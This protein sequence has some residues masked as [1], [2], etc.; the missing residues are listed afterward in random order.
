MNIAPTPRD[1]TGLRTRYFPKARI[2]H[3]FI[4]IVPWV[5]MLLLVAAIL[6]LERRIVLQPGVTVNLPRSTFIQGSPSDLAA[7]IFSAPGVPSAPRRDIVFFDDV[8]YWAGSEEDMKKLGQAI[9]RRVRV[10]PASSLVIH[11]DSRI[12][13]ATL[14]RVLSIAA[15]AGVRSINI[16]TRVD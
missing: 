14:V 11:A 16:A 5:N 2:C 12:E 1:I 7:V 3:G 13:H 15:D 8:R 9:A 6:A 10:H 4:F